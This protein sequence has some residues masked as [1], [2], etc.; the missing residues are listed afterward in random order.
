M[1]IS[2]VTLWIFQPGIFRLEPELKGHGNQLLYS[3]GDNLGFT[4]KI[5]YNTPHSI[6]PTRGE[7]RREGVPFSAFAG[8]DIGVMKIT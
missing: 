6:S 4:W 7:K 5:A 8:D 3:V 1:Y 2:G